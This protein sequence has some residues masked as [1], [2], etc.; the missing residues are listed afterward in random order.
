MEQINILLQRVNV[1]VLLNAALHILL[2]ISAG[3]IGAKMLRRLL[4]RVHSVLVQRSMVS[5]ESVTESSKRIETLMLLL[6]QGLYIALWV[7]VTLMVIKEIGVEIAPILAGAGIVGLAV[8]FGAQ[9]LVKDV[10]SGFFIILENQV[11]VGDVVSINGMSGLA[12]QINFRTIVLRDVSGA[13]H[14]IPN[15]SITSLTNLT[16]GWS[17]YVFDIGIAYGENV[18]RVIGILKQIGTLMRQETPHKDYIIDD[19]E[20]FGLDKLDE[21]SVVI[22]G[23]I[24]TLPI[25]QW[26]VG[27]EFLK[28]VKYAFD[29]Q[30][31]EIPF[32]QMSV[33]FNDPEFLRNIGKIKETSTKGVVES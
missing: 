28:R 1:D 20:I 14:V 4:K 7:T 13:V 32:P 30:Q 23:R 33:S 29:E 26:D 6:R 3:W 10:I 9:N 8:G 22:K 27:R 25:R 18:D 15:G 21:S 24:K 11:R 5:G 17:A 19:V 16:H 2:I 31:I 12:E